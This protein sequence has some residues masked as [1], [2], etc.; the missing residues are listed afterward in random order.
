MAQADVDYDNG[1]FIAG[2]DDYPSRWAAAAQA[3]RD[4]LG[5]RARLALPYADGGERRAFDLFLPDAPPRGTVVFVHGGYWRRFDRSWWSHFATGPLALGWAVAMPSYTLAP[6]ARIAAITAEVAAAVTA[7]AAMVPGPLAL[8]GHSA[9]GHLSARMV[10]ADAPLPSD[11]RDRIAACVPISPLADL[12]PLMATAMNGDLA[13]DPAEA[14]A[15]SP[16]SHRPIAG[17]PV[18]VWVGDDERPAFLDQA[19]RLSRAWDA[20]LHVA[21]GRHHF[22]VIDALADGDPALMAALRLVRA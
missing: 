8:T 4:A 18:T 20:P 21:A 12:A 19:Q 2:A 5:D 10:C 9:G 11:V 14:A 16:L 1:G 22:D 17:V 3:F 6:A 15:E 13:L 7:I